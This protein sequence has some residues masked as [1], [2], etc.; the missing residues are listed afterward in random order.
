MIM[1]GALILSG[2]A[3]AA[4]HLKSAPIPNDKT[5]DDV[6]AFTGK[7][8][9]VAPVLLKHPPRYAFCRIQVVSDSGGKSGFFVPRATTITDLNG[10]DISGKWP[11]KGE[12]VDIKYYTLRPGVDD[13]TYTV[14]IRYVPLDYVQQPAVSIMPGKTALSASTQTPGLSSQLGDKIPVDKAVV[15][16]YRPTGP[17]FGADVKIPF[18]VKAN[19]E[20]VTTLVQGGYCAYITEPGQ[21]E[22]TAF[23]TGFM[24]PTSVFSVTVDAKAGLAYYLKGAHGKGIAGRA[25]LEPVSSEAGANEIANCKVITT[26]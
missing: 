15:Y 6:K 26:Q 16:I 18:D 7:I 4:M 23:D 22:F 13:R 9:E 12:R 17:M 5:A 21:I 2:C 14:S 11:G 1:V 19:G 20:P 10:K 24:A 25:H 3:G 8:I